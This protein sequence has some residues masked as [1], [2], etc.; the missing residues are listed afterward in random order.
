VNLPFS[1]VRL[2]LAQMNTSSCI[3]VLPWLLGALV[4]ASCANQPRPVSDG[5]LKLETITRPM[6]VPPT[7]VYRKEPADQ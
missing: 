1:R 2:S 4:L 6:G 5:N 3:K 7:Y